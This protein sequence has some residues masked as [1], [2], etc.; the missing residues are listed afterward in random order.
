[1]DKRIFLAIILSVGVIALTQ[2]I[3]PPVQPPAGADSTLA[4]PGSPADPASTAASTTTQQ[5]ASPEQPLGV[6]SSVSGDPA[7]ADSQLSIPVVRAETSVVDT[8]VS[9]WTMSSLG[10]APVA[11]EM[12]A[13]RSLRNGARA[14]DQPPVQI[15][16]QGEPLLTYAVAV[17]GDTVDFARVPFSVRESAGA[18]GSPVIEYSAVREGITLAIRY[19]FVPDSY[20]V[21]VSTSASGAPARSFLLVGLPRGLASA[22]SD[23]LGDQQHLA[24]AYKPR[25]NGASSIGFGKLD[26]GERRLVNGPHSW[27]AA[28]SKYFIVGLLTPDD[29]EPFAEFSMVGGPREVGSERA[30]NASGTALMSLSGDGANFELYAGPQEWRRMV[31]LGRDFKDSNPYGGF[32]QPIVQPFATI[33]MNVLLWMRGTMNIS[34]GWVLVIF[35]VLVRLVMWPLNQKAMRAQLRMQ[36]IQPELQA[37]QKKYAKDPQKQQQ[38]IM[39]VYKEHGMS[40]F[41]TLSGCLPMLL[42]M[43]I[44]FA[45]FFV[46]Q[47]TIEFRGVPFL[48]LE[49]ISLK[50][51]YYILPLL[52]GATT[53]LVSWIGMRGMKEVPQQQ[54]MIMYVIPVTFTFVLLNMAAGLNLYYAVQ[55]LAAL[56]QQWLIARERR[57]AAGVTVKG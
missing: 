7:A 26:P 29:G 46:F 2:V 23:T 47:N 36:R 49:D 57:K 30:T 12:D 42:P 19:A 9:T 52:M 4:A 51:P 3:F 11:V 34:Y 55:N 40:P 35:G 20:L 5:P 24:Y 45:L 8:P 43:P 25:A 38:E 21:R 10:A 1:M 18:D 14:T 16:R 37:A 31:A 33:V 56:P 22:E 39:R 13:F 48:W 6:P 17:P 53:F 44:F 54:K 50:D 32:M 15:V 27:V 41:S 28:K